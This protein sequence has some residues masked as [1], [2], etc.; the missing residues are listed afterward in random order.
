M[1]Y[2]FIYKTLVGI[3]ATLGLILIVCECPG[4]SFGLIATKAAGLVAFYASAKLFEKFFP[5]ESSEE[6]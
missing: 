4:N 2:T 1:K 3:L 5:N 6:I